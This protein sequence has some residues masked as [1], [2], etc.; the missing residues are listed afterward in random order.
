MSVASDLELK[1]LRPPQREMAPYPPKYI[2]LA[3]GEKMVVREIKREEIPLLLEVIE[4]LIKVEEDFYDLVG[5]RYYAELLGMYLYRV[6]DEY[7]L[8]GAVDGE[9]VGIVNGRMVDENLGMSYHTIAIKRGL[10]VGALLFA[11]KM[12]HHIEYLNQKEVYIVAE[13]PIGFRRWMGEYQ[14]EPRLDAQHELGGVPTYVLTRPLYFAA[15]E[16]LVA[17]VRPVPEA[18][19]AT[20]DTLIRPSEYPQIPRW[21]PRWNQ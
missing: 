15:K 21:K 1:L 5:A 20:A 6:R 14:L 3:S 9:I 16:R 19:L 8:V 13:G 18:L 2:T 12:E 7:C 4:P 10:R 11:S 17:G